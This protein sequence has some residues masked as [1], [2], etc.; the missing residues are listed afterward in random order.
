MVD[1]QGNDMNQ[2]FRAIHW[3]RV[4]FQEQDLQ[5][6]K[7]FDYSFCVLMVILI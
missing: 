3:G 6:V 1:C 5:R 7:M 4:N 2:Y